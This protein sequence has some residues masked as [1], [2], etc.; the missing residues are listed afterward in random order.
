MNERVKSSFQV[1]YKGEM[2]EYFTPFCL[3]AED[4]KT[5][6]LIYFSPLFSSYRVIMISIRK[7]MHLFLL[8][9]SSPL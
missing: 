4:T 1:V 7:D 3:I 2:N 5:K 8:S 9:A 6:H